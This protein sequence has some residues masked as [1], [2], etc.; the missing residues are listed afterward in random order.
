[1]KKIL[2]SLTFALCFT[3]F[4]TKSMDNALLFKENDLIQFDKFTAL[5]VES[6]TQLVMEDVK[7]YIAEIAAVDNSKRTFENTMVRYDDMQQR[8]SSLTN[9]IYLMAYTHPDDSLRE[10]CQKNIEV[11]SKFNN[12]VNLNEE[13]YKAVKAYSTTNEAKKLTGYK[14]KALEDMLI[15]YHLQG[16]DLSADKR[17][18]LKVILDSIS[19]LSLQFSAN[20][21]ACKDYLEVTE[22]EIK[23]LPEDYKKARLQEN[24]KYKIELNH[25]SVVPFM[26]L[27]ESDDARKRLSILYSNRAADKNLDILQAVLKERKKCARLL[28]YASAADYIIADN[29]AKN[30]ATVWDFENSLYNKIKPKALKDYQQLLD[31]KKLDNPEATKINPWET[32]YLRNK[33][34]KEQYNVDRQ[35]VKQ[36][37]EVN[38]VI[39][40]ILTICKTLYQVSFEE[41]QGASVWAPGVKLFEMKEGTKVVGRIYLDLYPRPDKYSHFACFGMINGKK[42]TNGYQIPTA[43]L[44]CN[45]PQATAD[46]PGFMSH[47]DVETFFHEFGHMMHF[48]MSRSDL[49]FQ[50]GIS[51]THE[52]VE[53]P[54]QMFE[55]WAWNYQSL[56]LFAKHYKTGEVLPKA[57]Y[58]KMLSAR[59]LCS[60][61]DALRQ[62]QYGMLDLTYHDKY[63]PDGTQTTTDAMIE[64]NNKVS[65]FEYVPGTHMQA[66][67][68]HL[69][70]YGAGYYGYMWSKVYAED[71]FSVF[72]KEGV[73]NPST[74][75]K[76]KNEVISK[77]STV[78]EMDIVKKF[79][80]REPNQDAFFKS[81]GL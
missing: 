43:A 23:G 27:S 13:L 74:G 2:Y 48:V 42:T 29:M 41:V 26:E 51:N 55:N 62:L 4:Q 81:L 5:Q 71:L 63:D 15:F 3:N 60:G 10:V 70:G 36:Y 50:A 49:S 58:D 30:A 39:Q 18:E 12:E 57:L 77:G 22:D 32:A 54:S 78:N 47:D 64:L 44:V 38:N 59:N 53:V 33:V 73:L 24:G 65:L 20:I 61:M 75:L 45:F 37:F 16:F 14:K 76:Y 11:L 40:G 66:S 19:T 68:D 9:I 6:A 67:F 56:C 52:F 21:A 17:K 25:P 7:K 34:L 35:L 72:E 79:L 31:R 69:M 28:G 8:L 46:M 80:G 1:M